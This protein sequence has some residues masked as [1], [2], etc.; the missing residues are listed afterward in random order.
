M[1]EKIVGHGEDSAPL[2]IVNEDNYAV[3]VFDGMGGSGASTCESDFGSGYTKAYVASRIV[4]EIV[5]RHLQQSLCSMELSADEIKDCIKKRLQEELVKFPPKTKIMLKSRMVRDYPTTMAL[6]TV[7]RMN[8]YWQVDSFWAGDSR[9]YLWQI[10]GLHQISKDDLDTNADPMENLR[11]DAPMSNCINASNDFTINHLCLHHLNEPFIVLS[12]T[13]GCFGYLPSPMHFEYLLK[14]T[15][16]EALS[17]EEWKALLISKIK[18]V[19]GDDFSLSL[20]S[21]GFDCY[22]HI[23]ACMTARQ[24]FCL[25]NIIAKEGLINWIQGRIDWFQNY[26]FE[27]KEKYEVLLTQTWQKVKSDYMKYLSEEY[28]AKR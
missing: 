23:R 21:I 11:N 15:L 22:E 24:I 10:D 8:D 6:S 26:L 9:N 27:E 12:A 25:D 7:R 17:I 14:S 5:E 3:G 20:V 4:K 19:T 13:D 1:V 16:M 18:E 28:Y 2:S